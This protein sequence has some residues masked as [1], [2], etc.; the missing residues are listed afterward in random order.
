MRLIIGEK[1]SVAKAITPVVGAKSKKDGYI[2]GNGYIVS[3]FVGHLVGLKFPNDYCEKW[4][5]T[6]SFSQLP[7]F[8][9]KWQFTV[10]KKTKAQFDVVK[11]L[12]N[13]SN[14]TEIICA[15]DADREGEC[16]FRY[17]YNLIG[18]KKPVKRLWV[19][20]LEESAIQD[21]LRCMKP[22]S[23]YDSL[24]EAGFCRAKADWLIGMNLSR[25]F[26]VRC[27]NRKSL[28]VGRVKTPTLAMI[29]ERDNQ[30]KNFVKQKFFTVDIN[31]GDFTAY[32]E[33]I[34]DENKADVITA[35]C[36]GKT[37]IVSDVKREQKSINPPKLFD[38][39]SLQREAN[40]KYGY[41][42]QQ[43]LTYLQSLY[44]KKLATYP[45]TDSQFLTEDMEQTAID[46]IRI[47]GETFH[48]GAVDIPNVKRCINNK[49]VTGHHAVIPTINIADADLSS[50]PTGEMNILS[51]IALRL[52]CAVAAP[53]RY[54]AI[55]I[56]VICENNIFTA[57][58]K[59]V[60]EMGWKELD[61]K[62]AGKEKEDSSKEDV[63]LPSIEK[64]MQFENVPAKKSI[65][66]TSPPKPYTE[67]TL[68]SAMEHAGAAD[69]NENAEKKGIGTPAT[70]AAVIEEL[71]A[72]D[73]VHRDG[74]KI[75]A[76]EDGEK[77]ISIL[78]EKI[79][80]AKLTAEWESCFM[81]IECGRKSADDFMCEITAYVSG[82][83]SDYGQIDDSVSFKSTNA[84]VNGANEPLGSCPKCGKE[85]KKGKFGFYC[86]GKCGMQ[87][88]KV[89]GKEL[90]EMQLKKLL[91][92]KEVSFTAN[93]KKTIVMPEATAYSFKTKDGKE[94]SGFQ[95][96][97][98]KG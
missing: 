45:R 64:D 35:Q 89:Y 79:K 40:K 69:F 80:S 56:T 9:D 11:K 63:P 7:M 82:L 54:E 34:D 85:V 91:E 6:W 61:A 3:W 36:N 68:L 87:L 25:L 27:G 52:L 48:F 53:H 43:T 93:G 81:D 96:K 76:T 17:V 47:V 74:K 95:W 55:K 20:S 30:V 8:P 22:M 37:A 28:N 88:A 57:T 78:P 39:T 86:T 59:T 29:V 97:T 65:H 94:I 92:G 75:T 70:R 32:S 14:I 15:T 60:K 5:E 33:R 51:L 16:I 46:V 23:A 2:E 18:C 67:D 38:L 12:M 66:F 98:E 83:C 26:T 10:T 62:I 24:F 19:S 90:T 13:D 84:P 31:C 71:V 1:P 41:T 77:L 21:G 58:G 50:L 49:K 42:A 44:E 72:H 73:Y 4:S